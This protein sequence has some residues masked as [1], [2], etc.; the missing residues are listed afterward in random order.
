MSQ[1]HVRQ[2]RKVSLGDDEESQST[3]RQGSNAGSNAV[4]IIHD[5][6]LQTSP[7]PERLPDMNESQSDSDSVEE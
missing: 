4:Q 1:S 3:I 5:M 2:S 7:N 6:K